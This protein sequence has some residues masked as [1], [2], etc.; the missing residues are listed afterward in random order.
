MTAQGKIKAH[1]AT[2]AKVRKMVELAR[3]CGI[4][5]RSIEFSPDGTVRLAEVVAPDPGP[6]TD[7][8][9]FKDEL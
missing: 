4:D 6:Q 1:Y 7:F 3:E 8:D 2:P 5:V 9:R